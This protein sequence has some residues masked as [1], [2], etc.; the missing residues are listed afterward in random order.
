MPNVPQSVPLIVLL[1]V[2]TKR[3]PSAETLLSSK[4][5]FFAPDA[6]V[7]VSWASWYRV[8]SLS[9]KALVGVHEQRFWMWGN[10][11]F[12]RPFKLARTLK[13]V[14]K[15]IWYIKRSSILFSASKMVES[16]PDFENCINRIRKSTLVRQMP[17]IDATREL[18]ARV[19]GLIWGKVARSWTRYDSRAQFVGAL[20]SV[21]CKKTGSW[22]VWSITRKVFAI[23]TWNKSRLLGYWICQ[24]AFKFQNQPTIF[25]FKYYFECVKV[26]F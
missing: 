25:H 12:L 9:P 20:L 21:H 15:F 19:E 22:Q 7:Q 16:N 26:G 8:A 4:S 18:F 5:K 13:I 1:V 17:T 11:G 3:P 23:A 24:T 6:L 14:R 10:I 2:C